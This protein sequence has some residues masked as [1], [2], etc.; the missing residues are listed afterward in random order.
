MTCQHFCFSA[1]YFEQL[2]KIQLCVI[3]I[4]KTKNRVACQSG[5]VKWQQLDCSCFCSSLQC[6]LDRRKD[7]VKDDTK[8]KIDPKHYENYTTEVLLSLCTENFKLFR[9]FDDWKQRFIDNNSLRLWGSLPWWEASRGRLHA[10]HLC[11][12]SWSEEKE[13]CICYSKLGWER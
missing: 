6:L 2:Q 3:I 4:F 5:C 8:T 12:C 11:L 10:A 13:L 1:N 9:F 7:Q